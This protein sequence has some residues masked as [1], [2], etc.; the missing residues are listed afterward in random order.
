MESA[1]NRGNSVNMDSTIKALRAATR[2]LV[3]FCTTMLFLTFAPNKRF[4]YSQAI[5][6][7]K[8]IKDVPLRDI[9]YRVADSLVKSDSIYKAFRQVLSTAL[10]QNIRLVVPAKDYFASSACDNLVALRSMLASDTWSWNYY[11]PEPDEW[12]RLRNMLAKIQDSSKILDMEMVIEYKD[13]TPGFYDGCQPGGSD[14]KY[15]ARDLLLAYHFKKFC[16]IYIKVK[17][18]GSTPDNSSFTTI[19]LSSLTICHTKSTHIR[20]LIPPQGHDFIKNS[21]ADVFPRSSAVLTEDELSQL[22]PNEALSYC[23]IR[24]NEMGSKLEFLGVIF[25]KTL[26]STFGPF[27]ILGFIF[28]LV[29]HTF[30]LYKQVVQNKLTYFYQPW[31]PLYD[32]KVINWLMLFIFPVGTV[33]AIA[34]VKDSIHLFSSSKLIPLVLTGIFCFVLMMLIDLLNEALQENKIVAPVETKN[35]IIGEGD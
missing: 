17:C 27:I 5:E 19:A 20:A 1:N 15:I 32:I 13:K 12:V 28:Y 31:F 23:D 35:K 10:P 34:I 33:I 26:I 21:K 6:E 8:K 24:Y 4:Q 16:D 7:L 3:I 25:D 22:S 29:L 2:Y 9:S 30:E 11:L 14:L 18:S